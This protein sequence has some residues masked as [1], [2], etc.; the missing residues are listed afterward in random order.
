MLVKIGM[1]T[2]RARKNMLVTFFIR[3]LYLIES[4]GPLSLAHSVES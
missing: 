3:A 2:L 4:L 1:K